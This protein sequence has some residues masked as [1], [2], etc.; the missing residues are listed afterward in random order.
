MGLPDWL[1]IK[2][3][4]TA[5]YNSIKEQINSSGLHTVC[6][7][8]HC[9]NA[10]ECWS[11]GTATF[12]ILGDLCTRGC[13]FCAVH[14]NARGSI[15]DKDEPEKL[16]KIVKEWGLSYVVITSVCRDDLDDE[17]SSHFAECVKAIKSINKNTFVEVLI[18]DFS[19]KS[20]YLQKIL[21]SKPDV[22][23]HNVETVK[24][25]SAIIRD[26][27]ASYPKS[28]EVLSK[29]KILD[30]NIRTKSAMMLG[31]GETEEEVME[32]MK[33]LRN[34]NVDFL[35][36]GQYLRP[37]KNHIEVLEYVTPEKFSRLQKYGQR[38][39]FKYVA[40]G[41]LVRSSYRAGEFFI[42]SIIKNKAT[43]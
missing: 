37:S 11:G 23:G 4:S 24:R 9:P 20:E 19:G 17:G 32:S 26:K 38:I 33:D 1:S 15:V 25:L 36:I 7:E 27:R 30:K 21:D 34:A 10:S 28:L 12:M 22:L 18:P 5:K 43:F 13:R 6:S 3:A 42:G 2:P 35:A 14:K 16:A 40:A 8:A 29:S 41:P 31:I 39:G